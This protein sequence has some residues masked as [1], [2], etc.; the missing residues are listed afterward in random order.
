M[1][2]KFRDTA[3]ICE[4]RGNRLLMFRGDALHG[5]I[6]GRGLIGEFPDVE[7]SLATL[8]SLPPRVTLMFGFWDEQPVIALCPLELPLQKSD[9]DSD[10]PTSSSARFGPLLPNMISPSVEK[11]LA[12]RD[13]FSHKTSSGVGPIFE[14]KEA[15]VE[16]W[17]T[18][19][20]SLVPN[21]TLQPIMLSP[22]KR[23][24]LPILSPVW[25]PVNSKQTKGTMNKKNEKQKQTWD[26]VTLPLLEDVDFNDRFFVKCIEEIDKS[27]LKDVWNPS[28]VSPQAS[29]AKRRKK[30]TN[31]AKTSS[32]THEFVEAGTDR[33]V[34]ECISMKDLHLLGGVI[35]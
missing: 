10:T 29:S 31:K 4:A 15:A 3:S 30:V 27:L 9:V 8:S 16:H 25:V 33:D 5:V 2:E 14:A 20:A 22:P 34:M 1:T 6:P 32:K 19:F 23:V 35:L 7:S 18:V 21:Q 26:H 17:A 13:G 11:P 28:S 12:P 24:V